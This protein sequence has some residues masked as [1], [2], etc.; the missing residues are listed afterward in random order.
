MASWRLEEDMQVQTYH[1]WSGGWRS[2]LKLP[3]Q[4]GKCNFLINYKNHEWSGW[5]GYWT[6]SYVG[7]K[8]HYDIGFQWQGNEERLRRHKLHQVDE[9]N[10]VFTTHWREARNDPK[11]HPD[12]LMWPSE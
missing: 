5:H 11:M 12:A 6:Y 7:G 8:G 3:K 2:V 9:N 10:A 1:W 4:D